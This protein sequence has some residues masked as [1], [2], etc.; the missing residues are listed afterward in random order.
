MPGR[1]WHRSKPRKCFLHPS[2]CVCLKE[3]FFSLDFSL[4]ISALSTSATCRTWLP[5]ALKNTKDKRRLTFFTSSP[6]IPGGFYWPILEENLCPGSGSLLI[7]VAHTKMK[8]W[9]DWR[10]GKKKVP[11]IG[12]EVKLCWCFI[13][14]STDLFQGGSERL[15]NFP[16]IRQP[17]I[18]QIRTKPLL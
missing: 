2:H 14:S 15:G 4:Q 16:E 10:E 6:Q 1:G 9:M 12:W 3:A 5:L 17:R 18:S 11:E 8:K 13:C 7:H